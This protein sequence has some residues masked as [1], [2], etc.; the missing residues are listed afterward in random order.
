MRRVRFVKTQLILPAALLA[1][2]IGSGAY[3]QET[4]SSKSSDIIKPAEPFDPK[5]GVSNPVC[6]AWQAFRNAHPFPYQSIEAKRLTDG[7]LVIF[8]FEPAPVLTRQELDGLIKKAFGSDLLSLQRRRWKIGP[9]GW[10]EDVLL[11]VNAGAS[12]GEPLEDGV[13]RQRVAFLHL[14]LFGT[15]AGGN[16]PIH[17]ETFP[18]NTKGLPDITITGAQLRSWIS[19]SRLL[20]RRLDQAEFTP[21]QFN[22]IVAPGMIGTFAAS[23]KSLVTLAVPS[24]LL[25]SAP[26]IAAKLDPVRVPFRLFALATDAVIGVT[27]EAN[28]QVLLIGRART[29]PVTVVAPLRFETFRLIASQS[30]DELAQSY[31]RTALFA[32]KMGSLHDWAPIYLSRALYDTEFGA[33]LNITDQLLKS[34]SQGGNVEYIH[35]NYPG[36]GAVPFESDAPKGKPRPLSEVLSDKENSSS[37]LFN[38]NTAGVGVFSLTAQ[39]KVLVASHTGSLPVTYGSDVNNGEMKMGHLFPYEDK[40]YAYFQ[41]QRDAN[42]ARVVSYAMI[43]QFCRA[44]AADAT[45]QGTKS[46]SKDANDPALRARRDAA[47]V[48]TDATARL[49]GEFRSSKLEITSKARSEIQGLL[50][51]FAKQYPGTTD[52]QLAAILADRMSPESK[53]LQSK[54]A[55]QAK[56]LSSKLS[57]LVDQ[58]NPR[59]EK[60]KDRAGAYSLQVQTAKETGLQSTLTLSGLISEKSAIQAEDEHLKGLRGEIENLQSQLEEMAKRLASNPISKLQRKLAD[61]AGMEDIDPIYEAFRSKFEYEPAGCIKTPSVVVSWSSELFQALFT[62][63][64]HNLASRTLRFEPSANV[65]DVM[66]EQ[67]SKGPI[68]RYNPQFAAR[69]EG[70]A[71]RLARLVEHEKMTNPKELLASIPIQAAPTAPKNV[72]LH[73]NTR[74]A[75]EPFGAA[76]AKVYEQPTELASKLR[77]QADANP[78]CIFLAS[79][80]SGVSFATMRGPKPPPVVYQLGDARAV[81]SFVAKEGPGGKPLVF[82]DS[83]RAH[84]Q[85]TLANAEMAGKPVNLASLS[86]LAEVLGSRRAGAEEARVTTMSIKGLNGKVTGLHTMSGQI[87]ETFANRFL[88]RQPATVW[89]RSTLRILDQ[90]ET[91]TFAKSQ[92]WNLTEGSPNVVIVRMAETSNAVTEIGAAASFEAGKEQTGRVAISSEATRLFGEVKLRGAS[93]AQFAAALR[94]GIQRLFATGIRKVNVFV[95]DGSETTLFSFRLGHD[96]EVVQTD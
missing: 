38:W 40:A 74:S 95:R 71:A 94:D 59:I 93:P 16:L 7:S 1:A 55:D 92:G 25:R 10:L 12:A 45:A 96:G 50:A 90:A 41:S 6:S 15:A 26:A 37:V 76:V 61:L 70:S 85:A 46:R 31:E 36:K 32:G 23:D 68:L 13:T 84:V 47:G 73:L 28:G 33:L 35:F 88:T 83:P 11:H 30:E 75:A 17:G 67:T 21:L 44:I 78:C 5:C 2:A 65:K 58:Y 18:D 69:V 60:L 29:T 42:L 54:R 86:G 48:L 57:Q 82:I 77:A 19:D 4:T 62:S 14:A 56:A 8:L 3:A 80:Q 51:D 89:Q 87:R 22:A 27:L 24:S 91:E 49:I 39:G 66:I 64:G 20:W 79:D 9:D 34:W 72:A 43:Y 81:Q 52:R 53:S 63:G